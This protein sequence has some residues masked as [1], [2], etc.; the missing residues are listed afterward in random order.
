MTGRSTYLAAVTAILLLVAAPREAP[1]QDWFKI[2]GGQRV[3]TSSMTFLKIPVGARAEAMGGA[4]VAVAN[5]PF[6]VFWNPAGMSQV[7]SRWRGKYVVDPEA[8]PE[9]VKA[10]ASGL[11]TL[12]RGDRALGLI[13][14]EWIADITYDALTYVHPL[15]FG[16][17]GIVAASLST[18]D[19]EITTEYRPEGTGEYFSYGDMLFGLGYSLRMTDNFSWGLTAKYARETLADTYMNNVMV[20]AGTYYWT[21]WRDLRIAVALMNFGPNAKP[22]GTFIDIEANGEEVVKDFQAYSPPVEF[23]LGAA[24]TVFAAAEHKLLLSTQ[25]N[26]PIDNAENLKLG[27]EYSFG[28]IIFLRGGYKLNT[29]EDRYAFGGGVRVPIGT[30]ALSADYSYTDFGILEWSQLFSV[31][32]TF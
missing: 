21:G 13:S 6:A 26:H 10:P 9:N 2:L 32:I 20:D 24:M 27:G 12:F 18:A 22:A 15:P 23:R 7:G 29:D 8:P 11:S 28:G 1:A 14:V 25:L 30:I 16:T 19:M 3:G 31:G 5:D 4:Y 17:L